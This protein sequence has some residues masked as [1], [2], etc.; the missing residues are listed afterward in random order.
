MKPGAMECTENRSVDAVRLL[1]RVNGEDRH[2]IVPASRTLLEVLREDLDL[3][4]TKHGCELGEC[5]ACTVL[6]D[7][8][9]FLSCITLAADV[10]GRAITTIEGLVRPDGQPHPLQA[11]FADLGGAQCGYCTPG[12]VMSS[13]ALLKGNASPSDSEIRM[14]LSGNV[15]RCGCYPKI[16]QAVRD[17][18]AVMMAERNRS[19]RPGKVQPMATTRKKRSPR[20]R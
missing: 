9:P 11:A 13:L 5:G 15:C 10:E 17:A 20:R 14:G 12:M 4:G 3:T 18:A 19:V 6:V 7:D 16:V 2:I 1:L 8:D